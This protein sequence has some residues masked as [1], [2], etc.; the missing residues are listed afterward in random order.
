MTAEWDPPTPLF[1]PTLILLTTATGVVS[2]LGAPLVPTIAAEL[3][4]SLGAAQWTLTAS[5]LA[6]AVATPL[7]GRFAVGARR[8]P[9]VLAGLMLVVAGTVL[10]AAAPAMAR[11]SDDLSLGVLIA[12]RVAQGMALGLAPLAMAAARDVLPAHRIGPVM[13][14]LSVG[15]VAGA[16]LGY[17]LTALVAQ[18]GG[19]SAAFWFGTV[20]TLATLALTWRHLPAAPPCPRPRVRTSEAVLLSVATLALLLGISQTTTWG[21]VDPRTLGLFAVGGLAM[22]GW[23]W[24]TLRHDEPL[25]DLRSA[26]RGAAAAPNITALLA[27]AGMYMGLTLLMVL[28]QVDTP[29]G[30]GLGQPVAVAG[31]MLVP[32]S[33]MSVLGSRISLWVGARISPGRVLPIGCALYLASTVQLALGHDHVWQA[34]L[35]MALAG[36]GSGSTFATLPVLLVR[37]VPAGETSSALAFNQ[38][39]RYIGFS[40]GSAVGV[41][42]LGLVSGPVPDEHGFV[43]AMAVNAGV[44]VLAIGVV[45]RAIAAR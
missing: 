34:L 14:A 30:W 3:G 41:T 38:V 18:L 15:T 27:G 36:L 23:V 26:F 44:W 31:L 33:A 6:G 35:S 28:V 42:V 25:I 11:W 7:M 20:L 12:G 19:V 29:S 32:Y 17:P 8:R 39:L 16:G 10:A 13:A 1:V 22:A 24:L 21:W 37:A 40:V 9:V 2:S 43:A 5:L 4:V 45:V